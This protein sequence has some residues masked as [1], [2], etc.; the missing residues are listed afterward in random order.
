ML[1]DWATNRRLGYYD[2]LFGDS[3]FIAAI[4]RHLGYLRNSI[5]YF[6]AIPTFFIYFSNLG[7]HMFNIPIL[8]VAEVPF[9]HFK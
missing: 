9:Y 7:G 3:N 4:N 2:L 1:P 6:W 5:S 8:K